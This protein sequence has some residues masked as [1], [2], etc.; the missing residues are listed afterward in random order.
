MA[1]LLIS[2]HKEISKSKQCNCVSLKGKQ[3]KLKLTVLCLAI[4]LTLCGCT[5]SNN[6]LSPTPEIQNNTNTSDQYDPMKDDQNQ[7]DDA[8]TNNEESES[9]TWNNINDAPDGILVKRGSLF[10]SLSE[11][12]SKKENTEIDNGRSGTGPHTGTIFYENDNL[13]TETTV[14]R[15]E[16]ELVV[17]GQWG[18]QVYVVP[19]TKKGYCAGPIIIKNPRSI[20]VNT[21]GYEIE[22]IDGNI[23]DSVYLDL[24][25]GNYDSFYFGPQESRG[26]YVIG[27]KKSKL[28]FEGFEGTKSTAVELDYNQPFVQFYYESDDEVITPL[29]KTTEGYFIIKTDNLTSGLYLIKYDYFTYALVNIA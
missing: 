6:S 21:K 2:P 19:V 9:Q 4:S 15:P 28:T 7:L 12:I 23:T 18:D 3:M 24:T 26:V 22:S 20:E 29:T 25:Q 5:E 10:R 14:N 11:N 27:D 13:L 16:E 17:K 1:S 8:K